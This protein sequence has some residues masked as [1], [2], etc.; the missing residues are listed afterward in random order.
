MVFGSR[1]I[2]VKAFTWS[3]LAVVDA[4]L[5]GASTARITIRVEEDPTTAVDVKKNGLVTR[6]SVQLSGR[7][8]PSGGRG[9][10]FKSSHPDHLMLVSKSFW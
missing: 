9:W 8:L 3:D 7:A 10:S 1:F 5:S 2:D 4:S 6:F